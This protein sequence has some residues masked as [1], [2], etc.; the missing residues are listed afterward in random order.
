MLNFLDRDDLDAV[1]DEDKE[2]ETFFEEGLP[3]SL[4]DSSTCEEEVDVSLLGTLCF[5]SLL[6]PICMDILVKPRI[7]SCFHVFCRTCLLSVVEASND[8]SRLP[9]PLCRQETR[10]IDVKAFDILARLMKE[11]Y[12]LVKQLNDVRQMVC[13]LSSLK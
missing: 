8:R 6:C 1:R 12:E 10:T 9:C 5:D 13:H 3:R 11:M 7:L 2:V 4:S